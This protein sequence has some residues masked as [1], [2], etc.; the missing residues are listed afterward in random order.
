MFNLPS[1][2][3]LY[4]H[5]VLCYNF[6]AV[7]FLVLNNLY[8]FGTEYIKINAEGFCCRVVRKARRNTPVFQ[9]VSMPPGGKIPVL[10]FYI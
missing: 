5:G 3:L 6:R 4:L 8:Y 2:F 10:K 7:C 1:K 9:G